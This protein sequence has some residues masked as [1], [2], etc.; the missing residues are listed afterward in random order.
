[1]SSDY[2]P[3]FPND[4]D[5]APRAA[6]PTDE[7]V[8]RGTVQRV[9]FRNAENGYSVLQVSLPDQAD[10]LTV[11]GNCLDLSVGTNIV[12]R[13]T[14]KDHPKFGRQFTARS[15][16]ETTPETTDGLIKYLG[17][18]VVKGVGEKTA[19]RI[20]AEFGTN[21]MEVI[22]RHPE[23]LEALE[24][25]GK[26][27]AKLITEAFAGQSEMRE[28]MKFLI[29]HNISQNLA[30]K[31]FEKYGS[32]S[33]EMLSK[34]PYLLSRTGGL[35][36]VGFMTADSIALNLGLST[37]APQ[38]IKAGI[39]F[40]LEK[41]VDE[42]HC[43]LNEATLAQ[44]ARH[45]LGV[46]DHVDLEP[47]LNELLD[48]GVIEREDD[49][50]FLKT[51]FRAEEFVAS[52][53]APRC[54]PFET[55]IIEDGIVNECLSAAENELGITFSR[56]QREAVSYATH[57]PLLL[58][59]GGPGCGK[60]T[61]IKGL[62]LLFKMASKRLVLAAPTGRAAQRMSQVCGMP[63][64]TIHRLLRFDPSNGSF[65]HGIQDPLPIDAIIVDESSMIDLLLAKDLFSAI[66]KNATLILVGDRDQLPSVGPGRVFAD[67]LSL[68]EI[69]TVSLSRL[70]RRAEESAITSI[71]H[72]INSGIVPTIPEPD[73]ITKSDAY[74][75]K[76]NDPE[77]AAVTVEKLVFDQIPK[78]FG[79]PARDI[80]VLTPSNR[81]PLGVLA[82]N[83]RLQARL[84]PPQDSESELE[85]GET[86][87]R[88]GDRVCQRVNNYQID[89]TGVYN[90]DAGDVYGVDK[91]TRTVTVELWDGRLLKYDSGALFQISLAYAT[92]VHRSQGSEIP[93]V[94]LVLHESHFTLLE[95]QLIYTGVTRAKKLLVVV[96]SPRAL[97]IASKKT[98]TTKRGTRLRDRI[99]KLI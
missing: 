28:I 48:E 98:T 75:I 81:G 68:S 36:G 74:F 11:V 3:G 25:I 35:R 84:N 96:G 60:T 17:S 82:L 2:L 95:R 6:T 88:V 33:V 20:V 76:K 55:P 18:G 64:S 32:R 49:A 9:T 85:H 92:T 58:I 70:F 19:E 38:R 94:V 56:E 91:K 7:V 45:L 47:Y 4:R 21:T 54:Q 43:F 63:A 59:T 79:I 67:L 90:G 62:S 65:I 5:G 24:G 15:I 69:K 42:G 46:S 40:A 93:C 8:I 16:T 10:P 23:K 27:K 77:E 13:G 37:D 22:Y 80:I 83:K 73:G 41:S 31:I 12:V 78:K 71:A 52:F 51:L 57:Y 39:F 86:I 34:D 61:I 30:T 53:I 50:F 87:F 72:S 44:R 29:E 66:P 99:R 14:Y 26:H 1:M 97:Q 89:A